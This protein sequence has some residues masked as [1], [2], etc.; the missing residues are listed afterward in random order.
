VAFT[1]PEISD[2]LRTSR[3][4]LEQQ[5]ATAGM[6]VMSAYV[7]STTYGG[8]SELAHVAFL[9][10]IDTGNPSVH[11][12]LITTER[13][14]LTSLFRQNGYEVHGLYPSLTWDWPEQKFYRFDHFTDARGLGYAGPKLGFWG[15]P[16]QYTLARYAQLHPLK[17]NSPK[18]LMFFPSITS[19]MPFHP[20]P[21]YQPDVSKLL[22]DTPFDALQLQGVAAQKEEW[23]NMRPGYIG[24]MDYNYRWLGGHLER[25]R[26][27]DA[28][29]IVLGDH[30]PAA[31]VTGE[32][33]TWDVPVHIIS[34]RPEL[35][36]RFAS[37]GFVPGLT[38]E[39]QQIGKI[40][41]LTRFVLDALDSKRARP[42][43]QAKTQR[44]E[45]N[46]SSVRLVADK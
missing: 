28:L 30:Q 35:L 31:N 43:A 39:G 11:D 32:G 1:V 20:V 23:F 36:Q 6:H 2:P 44:I 34:K 7:G 27:R 19:H 45:P 29:Y 14:T 21:P 16:D 4:R 3:A 38:P 40:F 17:P 37:F 18:R 42:L 8:A 24:M 22:S 5:I 9:T 15:V 10:G 26:E 25:P 12:L 46:E 13:P 41:D 33:A